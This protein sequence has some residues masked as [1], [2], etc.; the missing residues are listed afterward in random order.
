MLT[1]HTAGRASA[2]TAEGLRLDDEHHQTAAAR[3]SSDRRR[4]VS[5]QEHRY[6]LPVVREI[7]CRQAA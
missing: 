2:L 7:P 6:A 5:L 1:L 4:R 3:S